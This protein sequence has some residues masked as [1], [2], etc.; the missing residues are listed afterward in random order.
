MANYDNARFCKGCGA[1]TEQAM[2]SLQQSSQ[3][4]PQQYQSDLYTQYTPP[5][6][7]GYQYQPQYP[8][9]QPEPQQYHPQPDTQHHVQYPP[10]PEFQQY[11]PQYQQIQQEPQQYQQQHLEPQQYQQPYF[12]YQQY[13][14]QYQQ[15]YQQPQKQKTL[16]LILIAIA[17]VGTISLLTVGV[18]YLLFPNDAGPDVP[19]RGGVVT[20]VPTPPVEGTPTPVIDSEFSDVDI[21]MPMMLGTWALATDRA[22]SFDYMTFFEDGVGLGKSYADATTRED[23]R[24]SPFFWD[25]SDNVL[26]LYHD[27][28]VQFHVI[29]TYPMQYTDGSI[30]FSYPDGSTA[31]Y[32]W[33]DEN[34]LLPDQHATSPLVGRWTLDSDSP[35]SVDEIMFYSDG[36]GWNYS[37]GGYTHF[38]WSVYAGFV[39]IAEFGGW[40]DVYMIVMIDDELTFWD[41]NSAA[42]SDGL[43]DPTSRYVRDD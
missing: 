2:Q 30:L 21:T 9:P 15:Q 6:P 16:P 34:I 4:E 11:E 41:R 22:F 26:S 40:A 7:D 39:L 12:E 27:F 28:G 13:Q 24:A 33:I 35:F 10:Q 23:L 17:V 19:D 42:T 8:P 20:P 3:P 5:Q 29:N 43:S 1:S 38:E 37:S 32:V 31:T 18:W 25:V 36:T 14:P